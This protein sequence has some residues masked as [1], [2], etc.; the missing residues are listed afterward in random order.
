MTTGT[1]QDHPSTESNDDRPCPRPHPRAKSATAFIAATNANEWILLIKAMY[2]YVFFPICYLKRWRFCSSIS[3]S[4]SR[5]CERKSPPRLPISRSTGR[6]LP[7][8]LVVPFLTEASFTPP[9][10]TDHAC[11]YCIPVRT[12]NRQQTHHLRQNDTCRAASSTLLA[13]IRSNLFMP[14]RCADPPVSFPEPESSSEIPKFVI[15]IPAN[16]RYEQ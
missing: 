5:Q 7:A 10:Q 8:P 13:G 9:T 16:F 2:A 12:K 3:S 11:E 14:D 1:A 6:S 4:R 15:T